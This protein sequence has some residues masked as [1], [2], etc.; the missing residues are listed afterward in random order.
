MKTTTRTRA[1]LLT[2]AV[3]C[4]TGLAFAQQPAAIQ[5]TATNY[6]IAETGGLVSVT[7]ELIWPDPFVVYLVDYA[8]A[9]A[10]ATASEDYVAQRGTLSFEFPETVKTLDIPIRQDGR[11]EGNETFN[12]FLSNLT[13]DNAFDCYAMLGPVSNAVVTILD[14]E[15]LVN[16]D[17]SFRPQVAGR[18]R[19]MVEQSAGRLVIAGDFSE[20]NGVP[21]NGL[22]RLHTDGSLDTSFDPGTGVDHQI[23]QGVHVLAL[24][25]DAKILIAGSFHTVNGIE[26][27]NLARLNAD[28]SLDRGF[29]AQSAA[30]PFYH[31]AAVTPQPD[32]KVLLAGY[33]LNPTNNTVSPLF[34]RLNADGAMDSTF[35]P[36][37]SGYIYAVALQPDGKIIVGG[38]FHCGLNCT[39]VARLN[40]DGT[41][42][43]GFHADMGDCGV[44][45]MVRQSDGKLVIA[46]QCL[47]DGF[48]RLYVARLDS[49]GSWDRTF[50]AAHDVQDFY[51]VQPDGKILVGAWGYCPCEFCPCF[52]LVERWHADGSVDP[53]F[54]G[55]LAQEAT[56]VRPLN[57]GDVVVFDSQQR[58]FGQQTNRIAIEF[59]TP[60][61]GLDFYEGVTAQVVV[62]RLGDVLESNSVE[63]AT[64]DGTA[65]AGL[66]FA[67]TSGTLAFAPFEDEK[68]IHIAIYDDRCGEFW[69]TFAVALSNPTGGALLGYKSAQTVSVL[70]N[71]VGGN[72]L[73][74]I[75]RLSNGQIRLSLES[76]PGRSYTLEGSTNLLDWVALET[77]FAS[78]WS[79][80]FIDTNA[81][82]FGRRF[83]RAVSP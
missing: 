49:D 29:D 7:V 13:C 76:V 2:A 36:A 1:C 39:N 73:C 33:D 56:L 65:L 83:Y 47:S 82:S 57:N 41:V 14:H 72:R 26:R 6:S 70:D 40:S 74:S 53:A 15:R 48:Y 27:T 60:S 58:L 66:D 46:G 19:A 59:E 64:I 55:V 23:Y 34:L 21:R 22:A 37:V 81:P 18:V 3:L 4:A 38:Y 80:L 51:G 50:R 79:L 28:G 67:P 42:D 9:D 35:N 43:D 77:R 5:L 25:S 71:S 31:F 75:D 11:A 63:Y 17:P 61:W 16:V 32:G 10:T 45:Y 8:T 20:V 54:R 44:S 30:A 24:Q 78:G 12:V 69:E 62:R 52:W 68:V